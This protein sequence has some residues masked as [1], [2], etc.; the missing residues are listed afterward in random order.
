MI[1]SDMQPVFTITTHRPGLSA[2]LL[3]N[4]PPDTTGESAAA[5]DGNRPSNGRYRLRVEGSMSGDGG[6]GGIVF[7]HDQELNHTV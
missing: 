6:G 3:L 7:E 1:N 5:I 2:T 4:V